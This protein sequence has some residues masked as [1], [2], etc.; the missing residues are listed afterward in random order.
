[1]AR[2]MS[3]MGAVFML[4]PILAP[5]LGQGILLVAPWRAIFFAFVLLAIPAALWFGLRQPETLPPASRKPFTLRQ[6]W[7]SFRVVGSNRQAVG[8]SIASGLFVGPFLAY[9]A[10]SQQIFQ[11]TYDV[12][13]A[14]ALY[15]STLACGIALAM[16]SNGWLV[17]RLGMLRLAVTGTA[18]IAL[19]S[20]VF[21]PVVLASGG[22]P[23]F[24]TWMAY[25]LP[26][27]FFV[28][29]IFGNL[30]ALVMEPLGDHAGMGASVSAV[31]TMV[32]GLPI[33]TLI[34]QAFAGTVTPVVLG[35]LVL[36]TLAL[37]VMA[38]AAGGRRLAAAQPAE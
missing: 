11:D 27:F 6:L 37:A 9:I 4:V 31:I 8:Y 36:C 35:F 23:P 34:G 19:L 33:A 14:F 13:R 17:M 10:S 29:L 21:L 7:D 30:Q 18:G 3:F 2:I 38:W 32:V 25:L 20:L 1:M 12:G 28:G 5:L 26:L 24:W 16:I 15:Y 22:V